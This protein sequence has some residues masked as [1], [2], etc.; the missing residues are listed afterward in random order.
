MKKQTDREAKF[1][2]NMHDDLMENIIRL[3]NEP[4]RYPL[5]IYYSLLS[6]LITKDTLNLSLLNIDYLFLV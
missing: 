4:V 3:E 6:M 2:G 5:L 1:Y